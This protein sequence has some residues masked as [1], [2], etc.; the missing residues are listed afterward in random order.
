MVDATVTG[1][2]AQPPPAK[3]E[4]APAPRLVTA[5]ALAVAAVHGLLW[6]L[7]YRPVP[8]LLWGDESRYLR[9]A[10]RLLAGD[11][12]WPPGLL[13]P[14]LY[15]RFIAGVMACTGP[16]LL[17]VQLVQTLLL[18]LAAALLYDLTVRLTGSR[19]A[20][21]VAA[22]LT[23][24]FP[25]LAA[26]AHFLWPEVLHLVLFLVLI[27]LLVARPAS[28]PWSAL[29]GL[30]LGLALL[31]KSLLLPFAPVLLGAA[32][33]SSRSRA[34]GRWLRPA[35]GRA[36]L[37]AAIA[38]LT[39]APT[40]A[41]NLRREGVATIAD[42]SAFNLWVGLNEASHRPFDVDIAYRSYREFMASGSTF[43][44][45]DRVLRQ[46]IREHFRERGLGLVLRDQLER[47][48]FLLFDKASYLVEQLPGGAAARQGEGYVAAGAVPSTLARWLSYL[49]YGLLLLAAPCGLA[50]WRFAE[51]LWPRVL[52]LFFVYNLA[53]FFWLHA[54]T[55]YQV[56]LLPLAFIGAG[57][58]VAWLS[59]RGATP[60]RRLGI[61][62]S[63]AC[64]AVSLLLLA[65]AF[66][67]PLL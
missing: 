46:R 65:L 28:L 56:Q 30:V 24:G 53:L 21:L 44:E 33:L 39:L 26:F 19:T 25:P 12:D 15:P 27:W 49:L 11:P 3:T 16:G 61:G 66:A 20:A 43:A 13:W 60:V 17:G 58:C 59:G 40:V 6:W 22:A 45:R 38:T 36:A 35:V 48:Y 10:T 34:G 41:A 9:S 51:P 14:P 42:S 54:T 4:R 23:A 47:Q 64:G 50:R 2:T 29:A 5:V 31:T 7:Y 37:T 55:R 52:I 32:V 67:G 1:V 63:V 8:K 18:L 57:C 62:A